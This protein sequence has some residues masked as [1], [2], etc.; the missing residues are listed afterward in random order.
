M[1]SNDY[2]QIIMDIWDRTSIQTTFNYDFIG[3]G[4]YF[5]N[6]LGQCEWAANFV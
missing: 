1:V 3:H 6:K 2:S 5:D 4:L